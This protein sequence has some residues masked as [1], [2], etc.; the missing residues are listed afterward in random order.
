M[1]KIRYMLLTFFLPSH[2]VIT[3]NI[4]YKR[5]VKI[6]SVDQHK[7]EII[8]TLKSK[9]LNKQ[10]YRFNSIIYLLLAQRIVFPFKKKKSPYFRFS[11]VVSKVPNASSSRKQSPNTSNQNS[12]SQS[13]L[14]SLILNS[15]VMAKTNR[16]FIDKLGFLIK[17]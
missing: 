5:K 15:K 6:L 12:M 3:T 11:L 17:H 4:I 16:K 14:L 1:F 13:C 2:N 8:Y 7:D 9:I 10:T